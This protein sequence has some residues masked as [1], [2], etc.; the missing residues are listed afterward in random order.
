[1]LDVWSFSTGESRY[2]LYGN[3]KIICEIRNLAY[4]AFHKKTSLYQTQ[5][6][7]KEYLVKKYG[8]QWY[9]ESGEAV[10]YIIEDTYSSEMRYKEIT[11]N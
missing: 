11:N 5:D 4:K 9:L 7:I 1:M 10:Q 2:K 8:Y 3:W 6:N